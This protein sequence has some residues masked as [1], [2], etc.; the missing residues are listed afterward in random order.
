MAKLRRMYHILRATFAMHLYAKCTAASW[1]RFFFFF[2]SSLFS[3]SRSNEIILR[4]RF[5]NDPC[6]FEKK[7]EIKL[8][9]YDIKHVSR[10]GK[11]E[12]EKRQRREYRY[13]CRRRIGCGKL[14]ENASF[15]RTRLIRNSKL[16]DGIAIKWLVKKKKKG[17]FLLHLAC[18]FTNRSF[19]PFISIAAHTLSPLFFLRFTVKYVYTFLVAVVV[20][21]L[22]LSFPF[23]TFDNDNCVYVHTYIL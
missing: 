7:R 5:D 8:R 2:F 12:K 1:M 22:F 9:R 23:V 10:Y 17:S 15:E 11:K 14:A 16:T 20:S 3:R 6:S 18:F 13:E 21:L 4:R 19:H